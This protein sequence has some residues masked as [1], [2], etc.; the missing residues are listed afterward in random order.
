MRTPLTIDMKSDEINEYYYFK[1]EQ[2]D[3]SSFQIDD[4][5]VLISDANPPGDICVKIKEIND[6]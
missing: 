2:F 1:V 5:I 3:S 6:T 4:E